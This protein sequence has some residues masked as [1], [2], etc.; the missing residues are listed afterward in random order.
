MK[1]ES[2]IRAAKA[3]LDAAK[4]LSEKAFSTAPKRPRR[5]KVYDKIKDHVSLRTVDAVIIVTAIL[6]VGFLVF[7]IITGNQNQ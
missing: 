7:G 6:I 1:D 2:S 3:E 4:E 5:Y